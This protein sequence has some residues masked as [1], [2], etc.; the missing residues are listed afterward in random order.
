MS[1]QIGS[2][3]FVLHSHL[4][5]V[6]SHGQWPH[7]MDWIHEATLGCYL[8]LLKALR[9]LAARGLRP[10]V[11]LGITPVLAEQL[12]DSEFQEQFRHYL[13]QR[14][15]SARDNQREFQALGEDHL[16]YL[17]G[18]WQGWLE[19]IG[20]FFEEL[21]GDLVGAFRELMEAGQIEIITCAATHGYLPLLSRDESVHFQVAQGVLTHRH[22]FGR[23][24]AGIWLPE[25]AYRPAYE[26]RPP[27]GEA[28]EPYPR[29]GVEEALA[30][31]GLAYFITDSHLL[32]GG[33]AIGTY[34]DRFD[35]LR[36]LWVRYEA[37]SRPRPED[38][39][40]SE[41]ECYWVASRAG[42]P[43]DRMAAVFT[44]DPDTAL[45]VWSADVGYPGDGWY[46]DFHKKHFPGG[47]K[48]WRVT[49]S[50]SDLAEKEP[51]QPEM[52]EGRLEENADHFVSVV[53]RRLKEHLARTGRPGHLVAPFDT[54]LFGHWWFE[55]P[56]FL[57][58]VLS[59][60]AQ[61]PEVELLTCG[62]RLEARPPTT[63]VSL[64]E[65]SWGQGGFHWIW[66]N[67]DTEWT[68]PHIYRCEAAFAE[69]R[70]LASRGGDLARV[71][72]QAARE[73]LLLQASD[74]QF[75][76]S[77]WSARDYAEMRFSEHVGDF[78]R[79]VDVAR[80]LAAGEG[81]SEAD[82]AFL[83]RCEARDR[84]FSELALECFAPLA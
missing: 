39:Q 66:L 44:R 46:L 47:I 9:G 27:V 61:D 37:S 58:K 10:A 42:Q 18:W 1:K 11:T 55:G 7:G 25:C 52:V 32:K 54:E 83:R 15:A 2:F 82:R 29:A 19:E 22:H 78:S 53:R 63:V 51:Y 48:Y 64:P 57:E 75:L 80:R 73:L 74:W 21:G 81:M 62:E 36:K 20:A 23:A 79:L 65:G 69:I 71:V 50:G 12:A 3:T 60:L 41:L 72:A 35:A 14:L 49:R 56:R 5:Y 28:S 16:A 70:E 77:T 31:C 45:T 33:Q 34:L 38:A 4:P 76:I 13:D 26:W 24:P 8:P 84:L 17:A 43:H 59:R 6:L 40:R 30:A 68:W 67:P